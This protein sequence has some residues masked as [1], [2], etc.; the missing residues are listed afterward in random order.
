M[1]ITIEQIKKHLNVDLDFTEDD[2][3]IMYLYE[4][5]NALVE[6][7]IDKSLEDIEA[8]QGGLPKPLVHA[9]LLFIG[10]LYDKRESIASANVK[11]LPNALQ[12]ILSLYRD[13]KNAN[14]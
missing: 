3:Y 14:I 1:S 5:S 4:V 9:M 12:Y 13:Y 8:E 2:E 6:K 10:N 7:H 11:E